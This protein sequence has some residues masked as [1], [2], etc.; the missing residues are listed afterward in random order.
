MSYNNDYNNGYNNGYNNN[1]NEAG[2]HGILVGDSLGN[3]M[4][5]YE[6]TIPVTMQDMI[7]TMATMPAM[8]H[9]QRSFPARCT[10]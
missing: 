7:T 2:I 10:I 6:D 9:P 8:A 1:Y 4:L 3:V 5:G